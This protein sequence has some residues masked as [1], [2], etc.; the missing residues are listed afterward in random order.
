MH[1]DVS[2]DLTKCVQNQDHPQSKMLNLKMG[3]NSKRVPKDKKPSHY[4][5]LVCKINKIPPKKVSVVH[6]S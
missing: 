2:K 6:K 1:I 4:D 3:N 5:W